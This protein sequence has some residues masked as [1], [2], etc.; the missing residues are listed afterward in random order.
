M[1]T[2]K[3]TPSPRRANRLAVEIIGQEGRIVA[4]SA[5]RDGNN[6]FSEALYYLAQAHLDA[7]AEVAR[8]TA[9]LNN[10]KLAASDCSGHEPSLS[11]LLRA[12]DEAPEVTA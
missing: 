10:I 9:H 1:T 11:V 6:P 12:I 4:A 3:I 5:E 7:Q 2:I 8:L